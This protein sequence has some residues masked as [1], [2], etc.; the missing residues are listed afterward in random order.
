M[1]K[2]VPSLLRLHPQS[3]PMN[4]PLLPKQTV[5]LCAIV[6]LYETQDLSELKCWQR[7]I[8]QETLTHH[9]RSSCD[10]TRLKLCTSAFLF[11]HSCPLLLKIREGSSAL[12]FPLLKRGAACYCSINLCTSTSQI[13][14]RNKPNISAALPHCATGLLKIDLSF[15]ESFNDC[16]FIPCPILPG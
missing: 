5:T 11:S 3:T 8:C 6:F 9:C 12:F 16:M 2:K 1:V 15:E 13:C 7:S 10:L 14:E 4:E